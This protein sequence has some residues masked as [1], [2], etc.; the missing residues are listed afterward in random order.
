MSS[1][2][3][4]G[5]P[6][7]TKGHA[8]RWP[9][10]DQIEQQLLL[11]VLHSGRWSY[12]GPKEAALESEFSKF[13]GAL[14]GVAVPNGTLAI[15][16]ALEALEVGP[17][18]EV[19]IPALTWQAT[20]AA[21]LD[22][23]AVP[24]LVDVNLDDGCIGVDQ[25]A[26]KLTSAT[27]CILPVHL[28][29]RVADMSRL[30]TLANA[31]SPF[32]VEDSA[33]QI[34]SKWMG[35]SVGSI[36]AIGSFS[37]QSSK[38]LSAGEGGML[39]TSDEILAE[40]LH[41]LKNCGKPL[42]GGAARMQSGNYRLTE[43]QSA[44]ALAQLTRLQSQNLIRSM[45]ADYLDESLSKLPGLKILSRSEHVTYQSYYAYAFRYFEEEWGGLE[46]ALFRSAVSAELSTDMIFME[47]YDPLN[48]CPLYQPH[49]KN[50][51]KLS[52]DYVRRI[53]PSQYD[54][55]NATRLSK[56]ELICFH[57]SFLLIQGFVEDFVRALTKVWDCREEL[58]L[59]QKVES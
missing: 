20:A 1:L 52:D 10:F 11:E 45:R 40:R 54:L 15:R 7:I 38:L 2:A 31:K 24:V 17:G 3:I 55:P 51:H 56:K 50:T 43:F 44:L 16:L 18:D 34:G 36:G 39:V 19:I 23:N 37:F 28:Y 46:R 49:V 25:V 33:H 47:I 12:L 5:G 53:D 42:R 21:A 22:V 9:I 8:F 35:R 57:H 41:S 14:F 27:K 4:R 32:I 48:A 29:G 13:C 30:A 26:T 6:S 58:L 59:I